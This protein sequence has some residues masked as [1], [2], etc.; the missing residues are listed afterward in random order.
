MTNKKGEDKMASAAD[1]HFRKDLQTEIKL[2]LEMTARVDERVKLVVEKQSEMTH[3]LNGFIDSHNALLNRVSVIEAKNGN[4]MH[5][6][7]NKVDGIV[8][9]VVKLEADQTNVHVERIENTVGECR[10]IMEEVRRELVAVEKRVHKLEEASA[11]MWSKTKFVLD[12]V[13]KGIWVLIVCWLLYKF[14]LNTP[15]IP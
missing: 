13:A 6:V 9:R 5:E 10:E 4:G 3:R 1:D 12:L 2:V 7:K 8:E 14:G 11:G 15:P